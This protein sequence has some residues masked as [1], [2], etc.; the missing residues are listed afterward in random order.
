M[1]SPLTSL[2]NQ[3]ILNHTLLL[4]RQSHHLYQHLVMLSPGRQLHLVTLSPVCQAVSSGAWA[5]L[6]TAA[7]AITVTVGS[8]LE[9]VLELLAVRGLHRVYVVDGSGDPASIITLTDVLRLVTKA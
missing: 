9:N 3:T 1:S 6:L 8:S 4:D 5:Q 2:T 7:P